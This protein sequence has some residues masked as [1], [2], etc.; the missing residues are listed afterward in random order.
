M[1]WTYV[2]VGRA[3]LTYDSRG[4]LEVSATVHVP[5]ERYLLQSVAVNGSRKAIGSFEKIRLAQRHLEVV[6]DDNDRIFAKNGH[7][8][9]TIAWLKH[10]N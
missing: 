9:F 4:R 8:W 7:P 3:V 6:V 5:D 1:V 10:T 2:Q